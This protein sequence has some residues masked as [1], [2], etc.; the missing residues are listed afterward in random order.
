MY[1]L[2]VYLDGKKSHI[3]QKLQKNQMYITLGLSFKHR[4][5]ILVTKNR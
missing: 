1:Y 5:Y 4:S 2:T 3:S